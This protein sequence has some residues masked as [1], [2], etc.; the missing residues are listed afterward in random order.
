MPDDAKQDAPELENA[1]LE[2]AKLDEREA[3]ERKLLVSNDTLNESLSAD[4]SAHMRLSDVSGRVKTESL[5]G[6]GSRC[7]VVDFDDQGEAAL[8]GSGRP[9]QGTQGEKE[10]VG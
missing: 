7:A 3:H 8:R 6:F 4:D 10:A 2:N 5:S 9:R 1:K